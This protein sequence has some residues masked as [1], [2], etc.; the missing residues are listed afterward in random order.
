MNVLVVYA[1]RHGATQGIAERIAAVLGQEG[2]KATL[3]PV[4]R[5]GDARDYD[6][7]VIGSAAYAGHWLKEA[8]EFARRNRAVLVERPVWLFS[9]GPLGTEEV[10]AKGRDIRAASVPKEIAGLRE[11]IHPRDHQVFFGAFDRS[12]KP[13]G[14]LERLARMMPAAR[15]LMPE[16]DFREWAEIE[17]WARHIARELLHLPAGSR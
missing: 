5:A 16:G 6:G 2:V 11:A 15:K 10:D 1:S 8:A 4:E 14:L 9:S 17:A 3:Q 13:V 7:I 12:S